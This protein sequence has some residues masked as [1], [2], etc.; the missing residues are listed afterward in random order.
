MRRL[1]G[2]GAALLAGV[3]VSGLARAADGPP[4]APVRAVTEEYFGTTVVDPYRYMENL[5]DPEVQ[6][7]IKGQAEFA[8]KTLAGIPGRET[9]LARIRELDAGAPYRL[10]VVKR[11]P[12]GDLHYLKTLAS[13]NLEKLY[14]RDAKMGTERLLVDPEK[15]AAPGSGKHFALEFCVPSPD[16]RLVLYG[17]AASGSEQTVLHVLDVAAGKDLPDVIDRMESDYTPPMWLPDGKGFVYSRRRKLAEGAPP[18]EV[19]K[20]TEARVHRLGEEVEKDAVVMAMGGS[21]DVP[22]AEA[23]FPSLVV[24]PGSPFAVL[25]IKHGDA[26]EL[27]L[28]AGRLEEVGRGGVRWRRVCDVADEVSDFAMHGEDVY[29]LT[30]KDA[31]RYRVVRVA[32]ARPAFDAA[33][34]VVPA[35]AAVVEGVSAGK[36]ALYVQTLD[37]GIGKVVRV[38]Y[39]AGAKAEVIETPA[40]EASAR[41]AGADVE[42]DGALVATASWTRGG[43]LYAFD[44]KTRK[45]A[46][47]GL[48]PGGKFDDVE[49]YESREVLVESHDGVR[50]PL[51]IVFKAGLKFDGSHPTLVSGYGAYGMVTS[52]RFSPVNLGWLERGGVLAYAHVRGGGEYGKAWHHAGRKATKPNTWRDFIACCEY[53][54]REGYTSPGKL[55]G[56]GGSAGGILIGRAVTE[57]PDLFAAALF[58]VGCLDMLR[59]ETTTN[60]VPNIPEF[61]TVTSLEGFKGLFEMSAYAHVKDGVK[62]P[63]VLLTHGIN[64]PRVEPW[65][66]AKMTARLQ[67][68]TGSGRPVLFRVDYD[69]GHGIGST[70]AQRQEV[71]AD[72]WAFLLWQM[73][74]GAFQKK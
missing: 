37:A 32:M 1:I 45:L 54:V 51:S 43:R 46:D 40:G 67:A 33:E 15:F 5:Q 28:Y 18:T 27:T 56:A 38:A 64:D 22:L 60:G 4:V 6:G 49:G 70:K 24:T 69:A 31:P 59:M 10:H 58:Q 62:Y 12:N 13:E 57:R 73:E 50:V 36:D 72:S 16:V 25:K 68:A 74:E 41:L 17:L 63:A 20:R 14:F 61:G 8:A 47:T 7:W 9:L 29:L 39:G 53:L 26:N 44:P 71:L 42:N 65:M 21:A 34:T 23:D 52:P 3:L 30:A 66:S 2:C 35:G 11:W 19:Y 55:A 48:Q